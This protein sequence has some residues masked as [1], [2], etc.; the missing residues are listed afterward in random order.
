MLL[1]PRALS[2]ASVAGSSGGDEFPLRLGRLPGR[3]PVGE[4]GG[5]DERGGEGGKDQRR[6]R[7]Q[8]VDD[9]RR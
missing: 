6:L 1:G 4:A 2:T 3:C 7:A 8:P 5:D 9:A